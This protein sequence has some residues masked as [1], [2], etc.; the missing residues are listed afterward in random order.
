MLNLELI[1]GRAGGSPL[2]DDYLAGL[3]RARAFFEGWWGDV[4]AYVEK[5]REVGGRFDRASRERAASALRCPDEAARDRLR[6]WV[7]QGGFAVTTGQQPGLFTG[8]LYT[9]YKG[10]TAARLAAALEEVLDAPVIPIFWVA[11][12]DHDWDESNH[13]FVVGPDNALERIEVAAP[14]G[15]RG[16]P[17]HRIRPGAALREA[18]DAFL[19]KLPDTEFGGPYRALLERAYDQERSLSE[20]F[21]ETLGTLLAPFGVYLADAADPAVKAA[22]RPLLAQEVTDSEAHEQLLAER[23]AELS[24]EGYSP[25]VPILPGA[26]NL[27]AEGPAGRERVYRS[28]ADDLFHLR[29]SG[30][31]LTRAELL[32]RI[33]A[34]DASVSPNVLLRPIAESVA[35]PTVSLVVGPGE[36]SYFAQLQPYFGALGIRPPVAHPRFAVTAV[37]PKVRKV[38]DKFGM[39]LRELRRPFHEVASE[40][41][42]DELPEPARLALEEIRRALDE[43]SASLAEAASEIH[44]T[45][46]A[47]IQRAR[48][49]STDAWADAEKKILQALRRENETRLAQ[50][51]KAQRHVFPNGKPQERWLNVFYYLFRYGADFLSEVA[52]RFEIGLGEGVPQR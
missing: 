26:L 31:S 52:E 22:T 30:Q 39:D 45:L 1:V 8:P 20:A 25:Q 32:A 14:H 47:S 42:R 44:T 24:Q 28:D 7:E 41:A 27:F 33:D 11:S 43:G 16:R 2:A 49:V 36:A 18:L 38:M 6:S 13:T 29:H 10:L 50:L 12:E 35:F 9:I 17:I 19:E 15:E 3:P 5:A 37:E 40:I 34:D 46:A 4:D 48:N 51:E 21:N 23:A